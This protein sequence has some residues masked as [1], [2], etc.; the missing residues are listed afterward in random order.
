MMQDSIS[1]EVQQALM[2]NPQLAPVI[3]EMEKRVEMAKQGAKLPDDTEVPVQEQQQEQSFED[4]L[5][6]LPGRN[7]LSA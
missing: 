6:S 2:Q 7:L 3:Q 5:N 4:T 1:P